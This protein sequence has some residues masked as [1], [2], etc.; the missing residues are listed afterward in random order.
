MQAT[1]K[2]GAAPCV[3]S[4]LCLLKP[5]FTIIGHTSAGFDVVG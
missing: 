3:R 5:T 4:I 2:E 1:R